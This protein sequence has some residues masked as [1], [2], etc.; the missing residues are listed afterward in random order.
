MT[1]RKTKAY[2]RRRRK[3]RALIRLCVCALLII[4]IIVAVIVIAGKSCGGQKAEEVVYKPGPPQPKV[5]STATVAAT[6]DILLHNSVLNGAWNGETYDFSG[7]FAYAAGYWATYDYMIANLE[8]PCGG[9]ESGEFR[10]YPSFNAPD[11]IIGALKNAGVDMFLTANNHAYDTGEYGLLRTQDVILDEDLDYVGTR[12]NADD[13]YVVIKDINGIRFG[14]ACYTYDTREYPDSWK[15]INGI[16]MSETAVDL[17][18]SFTYSDLPSL[19]ASVAS[20]LDTMKKADCDVTMFFMHWGDEYMDHPNG[21]QTE[22]A[23]EMCN[24]GVNVIIGGHPHV[25]QEMQV[26]QST[27]G[28][29][30]ATVC[31][32]SMGNAISSQ[33]KEIMDEDGNRGYTEDGLTI[34]VTYEK[35]NNGTVR[36]TDVSVLPTWV[37]DDGGVYRIVPLDEKINADK[38]QTSAIS[39]AKAS[40]NRTMERLGY[41]YP[42][43]RDYLGTAPVKEE[44][45]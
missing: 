43:L 45:E 18:N 37:D 25:I 20:D 21:Y 34:S 9:E 4:G 3:I 16:E 44:I 39:E 28:N 32:Y 24:M 36:L 12:L 38:W 26:L 10:G 17:I 23:Q 27:N 6:G 40:Y 33:R 7:S 29:G 15:S 19:Y 42:A 11:E 22:I 1:Q 31:L 35:L 30:N 13:P 5:E 2:I 14:F 41:A 8:V